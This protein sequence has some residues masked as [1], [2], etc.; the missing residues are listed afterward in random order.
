MKIK[1]IAFDLDGTLLD[2]DKNLP[3][4]NLQAL[5][6]CADRGIYIVP[7]TG[8]I[9]QGIPPEVL[10]IRGIR[11]AV[12][13]NG[14]FI[15]DIRE[16]QILDRQQMKPETALA[17]MDMADAYPHIMYDAY[18]EGQG[19]SEERFYDHLEDFAVPFHIQ[20]MIRRTRIKVPDIK[21]Y[22]RTGDRPVDKI[23]MYFVDQKDRRMMRDLLIQFS[24]TLVSSSVY[25][26]LEINGEGAEK[27]D[28]I[29]RLAAYLGVDVS[30]VM[31]FG[32]G[33]NDYSMIKKAG[34]GV[35]MGNGEA[36]LKEAADYVTA[37]N[38]EA[39]VAQALEKLILSGE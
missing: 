2:D 7:C 16:N 37:G 35:A 28:A 38:N 3:E 39:G 24:D 31:V 23:N 21:E 17:I 6:A 10:N 32:D 20:T 27:G 36:G 26:N 15:E 33:E 29:L 22:I 11:Y 19:I 34:W 30:Q 13:V 18:V 12:T 14:A 9:R 4:R 25:N 1:L 5:E 8:R